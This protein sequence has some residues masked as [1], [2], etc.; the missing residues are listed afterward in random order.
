M[1]SAMDV[2]S[3]TDVVVP[4]IADTARRVSVM[5]GDIDS[6]WATCE[7][8]MHSAVMGVGVKHLLLTSDCAQFNEPVVDEATGKWLQSEEDG[9]FR[10]SEGESLVHLAGALTQSSDKTLRKA[11]VCLLKWVNKL[12][13]KVVYACVRQISEGVTDPESGEVKR[14]L[15]I[16][17]AKSWHDKHD[18]ESLE[19]KVDDLSQ[20]L[21]EQLTHLKAAAAELEALAVKPSKFASEAASVRRQAAIAT[22]TESKQFV[23]LQASKIQKARRDHKAAMDSESK[24]QDEFDPND[25]EPE[26]IDSDGSSS[27]NSSKVSSK[28]KSPV[29]WDVTSEAKAHVRAIEAAKRRLKAAE[30]EAGDYFDHGSQGSSFSGKKEETRSGNHFKLHKEW[31]DGKYGDKQRQLIDNDMIGRGGQLWTI[32]PD[33]I[34]IG[35]GVDSEGVAPLLARGKECFSEDE[36]FFREKHAAVLAREF[37]TQMSSTQIV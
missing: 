22:W 3:R 17:S 12:F 5:V 30:R 13:K 7:N 24:V 20:K 26:D 18:L 11:G 4:A 16:T 2:D 15:S 29:S 33:V 6:A 36:W 10:C 34:F 32:I 37:S 35:S 8:E 19:V 23:T 21:T 27:K 28:P 25:N 14:V 9:V 31:F 1:S